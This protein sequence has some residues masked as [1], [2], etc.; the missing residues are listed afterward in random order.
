[1]KRGKKMK[2]DHLTAS[3]YECDKKNEIRAAPLHFHPLA[4]LQS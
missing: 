1:M 4:Y 3:G 2:S